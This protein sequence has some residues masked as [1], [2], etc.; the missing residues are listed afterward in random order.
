MEV[1][2][3]IPKSLIPDFTSEYLPD[4]RMQISL[5]GGKT[6]VE[7]EKIAQSIFSSKMR[8]LFSQGSSHNA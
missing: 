8:D 1:G 5:H 7:K 2:F 3:G 4:S 6:E